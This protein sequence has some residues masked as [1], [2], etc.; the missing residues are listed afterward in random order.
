MFTQISNGLVT[1][2]I[3]HKGAELYSLYNHALQLEYMWGA[4]PRFWPKTSPVLF[5]VVG[6]LKGGY[7]LFRNKRFE[8]PRHGFAREQVFEVETEEISKAVFVLR[9]NEETLKNYPF[10]FELRLIYELNEFGLEVTYEVSNTANEKMYFSIGGHPAFKVPLIEG[11]RYED[12]F[13][14]FQKKEKIDRW[15]VASEGLIGN[16]PT[17][18]LDDEDVLPLTRELFYEDAI[19]LKGL[20]STVISI[21]SHKHSHGLD[22]SFPGFPLFGIWASRDADFVCL[23]PWCGIGDSVNHDQ[24]IQHKEGIVE[25]LGR[26]SWLRSWSVKCY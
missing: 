6:A 16:H 8:L 11:T 14:K 26:G 10:S 20:R 9:S 13:L 4:D 5:P 17:P 24:Q 7:F 1:A 21:R 15:P 18:M 2:R 19:V 3:S 22:F 23:E 12:Y 25:L